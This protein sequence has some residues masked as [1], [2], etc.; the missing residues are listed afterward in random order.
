MR[1]TAGTAMWIASIVAFSRNDVSLQQPIR[2]LV[3][4]GAKGELRNPRQKCDASRSN[5]RVSASGFVH[6]GLRNEQLEPIPCVP[7][8]LS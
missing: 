5:R 3:D 4:L 8:V 7:P 6:D 2:E 1:F